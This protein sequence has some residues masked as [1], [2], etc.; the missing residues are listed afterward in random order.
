M[1]GTSKP[2]ACERGM[3]TP[4]QGG[5][6]LSTETPTEAHQQSVCSASVW[7]HAEVSSVAWLSYS[8]RTFNT[9]ARNLRHV[10]SCACICSLKPTLPSAQCSTCAWNILA[11]LGRDRVSSRAA[12]RTLTPHI[13]MLSPMLGLWP[14]WHSSFRPFNVSVQ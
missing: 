3:D 14:C 1:N 2:C 7:P 13:V 5:Q 11:Y 6:A 4:H 10:R 8:L 9:D 12:V